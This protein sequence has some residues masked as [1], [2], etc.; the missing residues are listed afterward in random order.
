MKQHFTAFLLTSNQ[1]VGGSSPPGIAI[2]SMIYNFSFV[3]RNTRA[4]LR[5]QHYIAKKLRQKNFI[6]A[7][8]MIKKVESPV[9]K[10]KKQ[11][12]LGAPRVSVLRPVKSYAPAAPML[13][14]SAATRTKPA[15]RLTASGSSRLMPETATLSAH[16]LRARGRLIF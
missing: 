3:C 7:F 4:T 13:S 10:A 1:Q 15:P 5:L 8:G 16:F 11:L 9:S 12:Y 6:P 14:R 2:F